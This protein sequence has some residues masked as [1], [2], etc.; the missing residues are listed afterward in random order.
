MGSVLSLA[1]LG[2]MLPVETSKLGE[3][4]QKPCFLGG[5][6]AAHAGRMKCERFF[7]EE[8]TRAPQP[9]IHLKEQ[10]SGRGQDQNR[11]LKG[12]GWWS[13]S[14]RA[15]LQHS[16]WTLDECAWGI[17]QSRKIHVGEILTPVPSGGLSGKNPMGIAQT[18]SLQQQNCWYKSVSKD[19]SI[20]R[21]LWIGQGNRG[22][23]EAGE[24]PFPFTARLQT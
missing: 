7:S 3:G 23:A 4:L 9:Y 20:G 19:T 12:G 18:M 21:G 17:V 13:Q 6:E 22:G 24:W 5:L 2:E 16:L 11:A 14:S 1:V 10:S 15:S 8:S